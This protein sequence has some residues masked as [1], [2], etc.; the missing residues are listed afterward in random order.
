MK[1]YFNFLIY[2]SF[3]FLIY[4]L[5]KHKYFS[6]EN[7]EVNY[8]YL[9]LSILFLWICF[10]WET[11]A[12]WKMLS[13]HGVHVP[14]N[15]AIASQGLV[16]FTK[17][18]PG[19]VWLL[20]GRASYTSSKGY[21]FIKTSVISIKA[22]IIA[23]WIGLVL[24]L[25][26]IIIIN[27][28][29]KLSISLIVLIAVITSFILSKKIHNIT[30]SFLSKITKRKF[31]IPFIKL[32]ELSSIAIYYL[33]YW[34]LLAIAFFLLAR[35]FYNDISIIIGFVFPLAVVLGALAIFIPGGLG[36]RE[37]ILIGYLIITG[38]TAKEATQLSM[39]AR[40]WFLL[41]ETFIFCLA[42]IIEKKSKK[43][44]MSLA[45]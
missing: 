27:K 35:S 22:Q 25:I 26:P 24:G 8:P 38:I 41:G 23:T 44:K 39:L 18:I 6:L 9:S 32:G 11:I 36:A 29:T 45:R 5:Y 13:I 2:L 31:E 17:Y 19:K 30:L 12:W 1:K 43:Y 33:I 4:F 34:I 3:I 10:L 37:G 21:S 42:F 20:L 15:S 7:V 28:I 14:L 16:V 40:L